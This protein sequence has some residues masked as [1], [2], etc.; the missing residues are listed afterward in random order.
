MDSLFSSNQSALRRGGGSRF[1]NITSWFAAL[2]DCHCLLIEV[3]LDW[4]R[5]LSLDASASWNFVYA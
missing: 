5:E 1:S 3:S 4:S 2:M